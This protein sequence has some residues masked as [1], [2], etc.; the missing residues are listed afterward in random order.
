MQHR[1]VTMPFSHFCEKARWSL[2]AAGVAYTEEGHCPG[3]HRFAVKRTGS[4][5]TSV[6]VL[7]QA[8]G[9]GV[10]AESA[11][12]VQF[13]D[14]NAA[15]DRKILPAGGRARDEALALEKRF[16]VD[17]AP[18]VRRFAYFHL[19][20]LRAQTFRLFDIRTPRFER[21]AVRVAFPLLR[22]FMKK[23]MRIDPATTA[24]SLDQTRREVDAASALLADGR[25][26]LTGDRFTA[27]DISFA[28]FL[29]PLTLPAEHPVT[30]ASSGIDLGALPPGFAEE[31]RRIQATPAGQFAARMY[32][33]RRAAAGPQPATSLSAQVDLHPH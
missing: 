26:F 32:R 18:H 6:P 13:A 2:D 30:G 19:L 31:A 17:L 8:S 25:P 5:R 23:F 20:P 33:E 14:A 16:D 22:R 21:I 9:G 7:V 28:A 10:L 1:L 27:A 12:I 29:A 3:L 11:D 24:A 15:S 4:H